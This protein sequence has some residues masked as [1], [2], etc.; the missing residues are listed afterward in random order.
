[1]PSLLYHNSGYVQFGYRYSLDYMIFFMVLLAIGSRPMTELFRGLVVVLIRGE[2]VP[3]D[4]VRPPDAVL[5]RRLL[6]PTRRQLRLDGSTRPTTR[7]QVAACCAGRS[8]SRRSLRLPQTILANRAHGPAASGDRRR[9]TPPLRKATEA[10]AEATPGRAVEA[11]AAGDPCQPPPRARRRAS[12]RRSGRATGKPPPEGAAVPRRHRPA[13]SRA[14]PPPRRARRARAPGAPVP[15]PPPRQPPPA[16][17][18]NHPCCVAGRWRSPPPGAPRSRRPQWRA[19]GHRRLADRGGRLPGGVPRHPVGGTRVIAGA[20][21]QPSG[22]SGRPR[23]T[24]GNT[25][26]SKTSSTASRTR[27]TDRRRR[28]SSTRGP[29]P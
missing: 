21:R 14:T 10:A 13:R 23:N 6:L 15:G 11:T 8:R 19:S 4:H 26:G 5:L 1:M 2:P 27:R 25:T 9:G 16:A 20:T 28:S 12:R 18:R 22:R 7:R 29:R 17:E 24:T 3:G